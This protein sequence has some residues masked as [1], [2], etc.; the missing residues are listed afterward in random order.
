MVPDPGGRSRSSLGDLVYAERAFLH[1]PGHS[2][3]VLPG[4]DRPGVHP[5]VLY[6]GVLT[7]WQHE[8]LK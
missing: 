4:P 8:K 1:K 7:A 2:A 6:L 3:D 5:A